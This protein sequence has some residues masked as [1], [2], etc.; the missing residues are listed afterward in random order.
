MLFLQQPLQHDLDLGHT[1]IQYLE[2]P[3]QLAKLLLRDATT[4]QAPALHPVFTHPTA[5]HHA[6]HS[7]PAHVA[8]V[9]KV[10]WSPQNGAANQGLTIP[11]QV[12]YVGKGANLFDLGYQLHGSSHVIT[13]YLRNTWLWERV[14]VHGGAYGGFCVF[15][16][17]SGVIT[18]LS[19]RDPNLLD[20]LENY[21]GAGKFLRELEISQDELTKSIVGAVADLDAYLLPDAKGYASMARY[22]IGYSDEA[23]QKVRD[24]VL[25][26]TV[27]DFKTFGE[28]LEAVNLV[29]Q[30]VVLGSKEAIDKA[31]DE[32][33]AFLDVA[34]VL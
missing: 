26:T 23:R 9:S 34:K 6:F 22:L 16:Q 20:T 2:T 10:T 7:A 14:R 11:A 3:V 24:E 12:N 28:V 1:R 17:H 4:G 21:D 30:V 33:G 15:D 8:S 27:K 25:S 13:K 19:Y 5:L 31:N 32:R 18:Y 29:G